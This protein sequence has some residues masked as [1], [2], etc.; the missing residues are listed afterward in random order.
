MFAGC[1][2][3]SINVIIVKHVQHVGTIWA[4]NLPGVDLPS[5]IVPWG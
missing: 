3:I 4:C 2:E 1:S 5:F